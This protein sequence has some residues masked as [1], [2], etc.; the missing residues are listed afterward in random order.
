MR[1]KSLCALFSA[2]SSGSEVSIK[3]SL[4]PAQEIGISTPTTSFSSPFKERSYSPFVSLSI[5]VLMSAFT[6]PPK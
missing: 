1:H 3:M 4:P 2:V 5:T 6:Y